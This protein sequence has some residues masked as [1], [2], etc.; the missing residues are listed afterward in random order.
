MRSTRKLYLILFV[1]TLIFSGCEL[2]PPEPVSVPVRDAGIYVTSSVPGALISIDGIA[3]MQYT[4]D[5][6]FTTSGSHVIT[7]SKDG[8]QTAVIN[9]SAISDSVINVNADLV[10]AIPKIV[11]LEDFANV[12]CV[13]CVASN[14]II[15]SLKTYTYDETKLV[16]LKFPTNFPSPNDPFFLAAQV[17]CS[18]RISYYNVLFAPTTIIDG[19]V[20]PVSSDSIKIKAAIEQRFAEIPK[21]K[22]T[23]TDTISGGAITYKVRV[24][25]LDTAGISTA[26][27]ALR[28]VVMEEEIIFSTPPGSNGE[29]QFY[30][31]V[32]TMLPDQN[33][34][35]ITTGGIAPGFSQEFTL[36]TPINP[37]WQIDEIRGV[38]FVQNR[39]TR[40]V[41]QAAITH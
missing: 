7:L 19:I 41:Y 4:P 24:V 9:V 20:K 14:L 27:L 35:T 40:E 31:V 39:F 34:T 11:L 3:Q 6:V 21:F 30:D 32:R 37:V 8:Y 25:C 29:T 18:A 33:G 22:V 5:T 28:F 15:K 1:L 16:V 26:N 12:S 10:V 38:A 17:Y 23:L 2:A 13:P 36:S